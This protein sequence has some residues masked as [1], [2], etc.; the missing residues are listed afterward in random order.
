MVVA[1]SL[2]AE[3]QN[4]L[5]FASGSW[6][7]SFEDAPRRS[8]TEN[9]PFTARVDGGVMFAA[10]SLGLAS[11][12]AQAAPAVVESQGAVT[13]YPPEYFREAA[14]TTAY[15]MVIRL[16]GF[17]FDKGAAV[18]GLSGAGGN[19][20]IDGQPPVSKNDPLDEILKR[21]PAD[22]VLRIEVIRGGSAGID[23]QGKTIVA[24]VVRRSDANF[25]GVL[26]GS[27]TFVYDGRVEPGMR[28]EGQWTWGK[29]LLELSYIGGRGVDDSSGDGPR[30]RYGPTGA[31]L[32]RS[33][34]DGDGE[35][36]REW[37][38][39]AFETPL[40]PGRLRLNGALQRSPYDN[41]VTDRLSFP[42]GKEYQYDTVDRRQAEL[43]GRY[44][45]PLS[46]ST[47][48][49]SVALQQWS[50]AVTRARFE[51]PG[52]DRTFSLDRKTSETVGRS[53]ARHRVSDASEFE[54]GGEVALNTL[55]GETRL[56]VNSRPVGV[57]SAN[58]RTE[59]VRGEAYGLTRWRPLPQLTVEATLRQERSR[60][61]ASGDTTLE[62]TLAFTK[63]RLA[64]IYR[65]G[66][67]DQIRLRVEREVNQLSFDDFVASSSFVNTGTVISGNPD[68]TPQQAWVGEIAYEKRFRRGGAAVL[69]WRRSELSDVIDRIAII[70]PNG[71]VADAP[72]NIGSGR[73]DELMA[74]ITAPL[75]GAGVSGGL[76]KAQ[77]TWRRSRVVDP[78]TQRRREISGLKPVEWEVRF[79]QNI[80]RLNTTWGAD[81]TGGFRERYYRLSEVETRKV[82]TW[83]VLYAEYKLKS[84]LT[85]R[86]EMQ[87]ALS[88]NVK[89]IRE[90][91]AGPRNAAPIMYTDVRDLEFGHEFYIRFRQTF[92]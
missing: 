31:V 30:I 82:S 54:V 7:C 74:N 51:G 34:V 78:I 69:T 17:V 67:D 12:V 53:L 16:P 20:L 83:V 79:S 84:N 92:D 36:V 32:M 44:S 43:G 60:I 87:N 14:P 35:S 66:P 33:R 70:A 10:V 64:A 15:D 88:R 90:V 62:K 77:L 8:R 52:V 46:A 45:L 29:R 58:V 21:I 38:T 28:A 47:T 25:R 37:F 3:S 86:I 6:W 57:P 63:P 49:E 19:V 2:A 9:V 71:S 22:A 39:G 91:Y 18:R 55:D 68:L 75:T 48:L 5:V 11:I 65:L 59:E 50:E 89:R 4:A 80:P 56:V 42:G 72:G 26:I 40:G 41:E 85:V 61:T 76:L 24:N 81:V 13:P 27:T 23:M 1:I 73:R